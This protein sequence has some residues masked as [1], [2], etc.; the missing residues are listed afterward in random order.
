MDVNDADLFGDPDPVPAVAELAAGEL[1][2]V[3]QTTLV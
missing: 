1:T 2:S 3:P